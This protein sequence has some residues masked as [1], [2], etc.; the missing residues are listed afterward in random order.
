MLLVVATALLFLATAA[1]AVFTARM[2]RATN[3]VARKTT[4]LAQETKDLAKETIAANVLADRHHQEA[5]TP[6]VV[7]S[8]GHVAGGS[9]LR[10]YE[11]RLKNIGPGIALDVCVSIHEIGQVIQYGSIAANGGEIE[12][13]SGCFVTITDEAKTGQGV[14]IALRY[15]NLFG[16]EAKT[17]HFG[18]IGNQTFTTIF[19]A[20]AVVPNRAVIKE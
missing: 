19:E 3:T 5:M 6:C 7:L 12:L 11:G 8:H 4:E 10:I 9:E 15:K 2:A 16:A 1:L 17:T 13:G 18:Q 20:P 14:K